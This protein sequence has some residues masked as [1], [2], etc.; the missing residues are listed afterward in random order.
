VKAAECIQALGLPESAI[1]DQR[2]PKKTLAEHG[3][4][5]AAARRQIQEGIEELRWVAALKPSTCGVPSYTD[6]VRE[7][8]ELAVLRLD[9]R[10][11]AKP[12][13]LLPLIHRAIPY[14]VVLVGSVADGDSLSLA[15]KRW[16]QAEKG[17]VVLDGELVALHLDHALPEESRQSFLSALS[18]ARQPRATLYDL[19]QGWLDTVLAMQAASRLGDFHMPRSREHADA[20]N[21]ALR[22]CERLESE[23]AALRAAADREKQLPRRVELNLELKRLAEAHAAARARL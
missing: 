19:Y 10:G 6:D 16:S 9:L 14:P 12:G 15:H 5:T 23:M 13:A 21:A 11:A 20:R 1:V 17:R 2:V 4:G 8:L 7:Y 22:E 3:A 18:L